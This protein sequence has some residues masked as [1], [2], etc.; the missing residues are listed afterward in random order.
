MGFLIDKQH[1]YKLRAG[2]NIDPPILY[3]STVGTTG[4]T[5]LSYVA[6]F[7]TLVGESLP[8]AVVTVTDAPAVRTAGNYIALSV[9]SVP[10]GVTS[11][12]YYKL[13]G[14]QYK[15]LGD[16]VTSTPWTLKD[17]GTNSLSGS[18][19][20]P[21]ED[22][23]G[24]PQW[25][26]M[27]FHAGRYLQRQEL[28]DLQWL[29]QRSNKELGDT[30]H[31]NGDIIEGLAEQ[32]VS[33]TTWNFTDGKIYLDGQHVPITGDSVTLT[34]SGKEVVGLSITPTVVTSGTDAY[35]KN[36]DEGVD[37]QYAQAG[38]DRL[39]YA[40]EWVVDTAGQVDIRE[41]LNNSPVFKVVVTERTELQ[42]EMARRTYDTSGNYTVRP[43]PLKMLEDVDGDPDT[44]TA[45]IYA[46]KAYVE[47]NEIETIAHQEVAV[48]KA[49]EVSS[50]NNSVLG[51]F[52]A[53]G[54]YTIG[55][56][57]ENFDVDGLAVKL[58]VGSG[59]SHTVTFSGNGK[60]AA[61]VAAAI[62][63][64]VNAYPTDGVNQ[65]LV[66]CA[67]SNGKVMIK[68]VDG[69]NLTIEAVASDAYTVLGVSTGT[70][71][72]SGTRI[73]EMDDN[74]VKEVSDLSYISE[75]VEAVTRDG[76]S[77][78]DTLE[79]SASTLIGV[80][81][82]AANA[83]DGK[84]DYIYLTDFKRTDGKID[85]SLGGSDPSNGATYYLKYRHSY[86][87]VRRT[88]T[89]VRVVDATITK[90]T[91]DG[92]DTIV[93]TGGTAT[94]VVSGNPVAGLSGSAS[95][96]IS[97]L[98]VN[99][100]AGQSTDQY[101]AYSLIKNSSDNPSIEFGVSQIDWSAAGTQGTTGD[102]QP[103]VGAV[104][105]C[106]FEYW[107]WS[108]TGDYI[109]PDSYV[110]DY[111]EI[112]LAPDDVTQ[113]RDCIDFRRMGATG[114]SSLIL[115]APED[116]PR[117]DYDF[118]LARVDKIALGSDGYFFRI[119]G[120]PAEVPQTPVNQVGP[121]SV[122]QLII[123]PYTYS[124]ESVGK[125]DLHVLRKTQWS[126]NEMQ[127]Q[128]DRLKYQAAL[129]EVQRNVTE[130][131]AAAEAKGIFTD[132]LVGHKH[133]DVSFSKNGITYNV[134]LDP[135]EQCL[136][137]PAVEDGQTIS[138][139][140][141]N[142]T[143]IA[144]VG[145]VVVFD[146]SPSVFLSQPKATSILNVN[147]N[148]VFGWIGTMDVVPLEDF[149][150]DVNQL[151]AIDTNYD[152]QMNWVNA[153]NAEL[154]R[155]VV[156]GSWRLTS[157]GDSWSQR[158][159]G[160]TDSSIW[161]GAGL[162]VNSTDEWF[163]RTN[164][165]LTSLSAT[166]ERTGSYNQLVPE[167]TLVE[168]GDQVV[169]V[170]VL[171]Y[172]R[173]TI[174]GGPFYI[175]C[176]V[177]GVKP[178]TDMACTIDGIAVDLLPVSPSVAGILTWRSKST[179]A[180][181]G[182]GKLT[183]RFVMPEG[184]SVGAKAIKVFSASDPDETYAIGVFTSQGFRETRQKTYMGILNTTERTVVSTETEFHYGDPLAQTFP[185]ESGIRW[186]SYVKLYFQSKD[187]TLPVTVEIRETYNG[188][189]TMKVLQS[190]TLYP[191]EI[192]ISDDASAATTFTF[193]E[194]VGYQ[195]GEYCIVVHC[196]ST[197]YNLWIAK[198][199][200]V[201]ISDGT[202]V[203][204][205]PTGGVLFTSPNNS[206]WE[207]HST[208]DM[209]FEI[210]EANF[211]NNAQVV[212][213]NITGLQASAFIAAVTHLMPVGTNMFWKYST[214]NGSS[215]TA[216]IPGI[217]TNLASVASQVKI[218][219]DV[220]GSGATFQILDSGAGIIALLNAEEGDY[221]STNAEF[222]DN[223]NEVVVVADIATDGVNGSGARSVTPYYSI[224]DGEIWVELEPTT[225]F[226]PTNVGDGTYKEYTFTTRGEVTISAATNANPIVC[227]SAGHGYKENTVVYLTGATGNTNVNGIRRIVN[228]DADT[229]ELVD[230]TTGSNIAGNG[231]FGGTC[232]MTV[233]DFDQ[234]RLR[235]Y[236]ETSN[237]VVTPKVRKVRGICS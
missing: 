72:V 227:T 195:A 193:N 69:K 223:C 164:H 4:S 230:A 155:Q 150:T 142:S 163:A 161:T 62:N 192:N 23:S 141:V 101:T 215:W 170:T 173:T 14:G 33:G 113:L 94:E 148:E 213:D 191:A 77:D 128:I 59:N 188:Y 3:A 198:M 8:T 11:V 147:P 114:D 222:D 124:P 181:S 120:S 70:Y 42:K 108:A 39:V 44:M 35:I 184:V 204:T 212:F 25:R 57:S 67:A 194:I 182:A 144:K 207:P 203:R 29:L 153:T 231:T 125:V 31:K 46:G 95:D 176:E 88:K 97:I 50:V 167:R 158:N 40:I 96:V 102:G 160:Q 26:A 99:T 214:D 58:K 201:N 190:K 131:P 189:P 172:C 136:R 36:Q 225:G 63:S 24:R 233:N 169:D 146:Y 178:S 100:T 137:L 47:G 235:M 237:R 74:Y 208:W 224:D 2:D 91:E 107:K 38:A 83:H 17:D 157:G 111:D 7:G 49:R 119:P 76:G 15:L 210:G 228:V 200:E 133:S 51:S 82:T 139:D 152:E 10:A 149:W 175:N 211:Q 166:R 129:V 21:T 168:V 16:P 226:V 122:W 151:P 118:Y 179:V 130:N 162:W 1:D 143:N 66:Q 199:G 86:N 232:T 6:T 43:F 28:M 65:P 196:N 220:T 56:T 98:R 75:R 45:Y 126:I 105:Y 64:S 34:G 186:L 123:P 145:S 219:C 68:A 234:C 134:A 61:Q 27:L 19:I 177:H 229:F 55:T 54:G 84:F 22:T 103:T 87:P 81:N 154:A 117:L 41:F 206:T 159:W 85:W 73:Y 121:L 127:M 18:V 104:Y 112:E 202:I 110:N 60:T 171:P 109:A 52:D 209:M 156:W 20:A 80:S 53:T 106:T 93:F 32:F 218:S 48:P 174:D 92:Q 30:I 79:Y 138:V 89:R 132:S 236:L 90:G 180:S 205:Q 135:S 115:P 216:F 12:R 71:Y 217:D 13:D 37:L 183:A 9:D 5:S 187:A 78:T 185:V 116:S 197:D 140:M 221:I 165:A